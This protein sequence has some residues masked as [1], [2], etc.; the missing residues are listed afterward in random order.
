MGDFTEFGIE[1]EKHLS[2]LGKDI[3]QF[4]EK[5]V[6]LTHDDKD[7]APDCD[8][9]ESEAE[10]KVQIDLPGLAKKEIGIA[11][12]NNVLTIK[13]ERD[14]QAGEGEEFKR[15]ER[16]RGAFARSF[17]LPEN[18]NAAEIS[19][20][21]RNGVLTVAMPKSDKLKDTTSIPVN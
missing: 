16:K 11:L 8:I 17:A 10:Y 14:I 3:Q 21:F 9:L 19:A 7:F 5:V 1:I 13:G 20:S 18:V 15:Q 6:P 2:K 12:K 4:V